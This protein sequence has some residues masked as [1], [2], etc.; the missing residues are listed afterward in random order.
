MHLSNIWHLGVKELR[1]LHRDPIVLVLIVY[2]I[3][4]AMYLGG[5]GNPGD[6]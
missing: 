6:Y 3:T 4:R 5:E 2:S 1:G